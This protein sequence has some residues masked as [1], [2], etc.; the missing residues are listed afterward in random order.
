MKM[1][2]LKK[3]KLVTSNT[4]AKWMSMTNHMVSVEKWINTAISGRDIST[5]PKLIL[6]EV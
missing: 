4:S 5:T 3:S 6:S 2:R 1:L